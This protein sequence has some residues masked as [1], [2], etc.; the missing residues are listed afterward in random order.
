MNPVKERIIGAVSIMNDA[1][2]KI[3][4]DMITD[5]FPSR[6]WEDIEEV[7]PDE[8]DLEMLR[9]IADDPDYSTFVSEEEAMR[10]L[11]LK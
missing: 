5:I 2:A 7:E 4:W 9:E 10:M 11:G 3:V 6:S 1:D 8:I